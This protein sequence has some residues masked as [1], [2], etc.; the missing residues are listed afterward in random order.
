MTRV[1]DAPRELVFEALTRPE[2]VRRWLGALEGWTFEI[3]EIDARK[4]GSYRYL[5][6]HADGSELGMRGVYLEVTPPERIVSTE[7]FDQAWY[8]GDA[9]GTATL[10]ERDGKTTLS[11]TIRYGSKEI[12]DAVL[13]SPME[14]G[15]SQGYDRLEELLAARAA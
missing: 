2:L 6:R 1:F 12:R 7:V 10:T 14:S 15:V 9:V 8:E 4:G 13:R 3:C 5:W 11:T